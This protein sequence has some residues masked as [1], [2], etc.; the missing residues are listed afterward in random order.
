MA[1]ASQAYL[2]PAPHNYR[3]CTAGCIGPDGRA[4]PH[5]GMGTYFAANESY[6]CVAE[7]ETR[8]CGA[9]TIGSRE[10]WDIGGEFRTSYCGYWGIVF[11]I[12][13]DL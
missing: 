10:L 6:N 9:V 3:G 2:T 12:S 13:F 4:F 5:N 7:T 11:G 8:T 1:S